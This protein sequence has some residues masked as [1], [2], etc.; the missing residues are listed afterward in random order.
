MF[1]FFFS[2][3]S[4]VLISIY[5]LDSTCFSLFA[6]FLVVMWHCLL[7]CNYKM[8]LKHKVGCF[9]SFFAGFNCLDFYIRWIQHVSVF[10]QRF[11]VVMWHFLLLCNYKMFLKHKVGCFFSFFA[12]F[13]CLDFY[14]RWIQHVVHFFCIF[15]VVMLPWLLLCNYKMLKCST[16]FCVHQSF[17]AFEDYLNRKLRLAQVSLDSTVLIFIF[18]GFNLWLFFFAYL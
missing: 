15:A 11:L 13:N 4:T 1:L 17:S 16:D 6:Y 10:L 3:D 2:L 18:A 5:S 14:I 12:G 7:L 8:L 9:F